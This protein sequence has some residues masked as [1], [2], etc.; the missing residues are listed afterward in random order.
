MKPYKKL[1]P[2]ELGKFQALLLG[3]FG[4][5]LGIVYSF[6]GLIYD[7]I[8]THTVNFGTLLAFQALLAMPIIFGTFGFFLGIIE[9]FLYNLVAK[10][11]V[12][13]RQY[14]ISINSLK[15]NKDE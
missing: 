5:L 7:L 4:I 2:F 1:L 15:D 8:T 9:A 10:Y 14:L 3:L 11:F 13:I 6:G 12:W